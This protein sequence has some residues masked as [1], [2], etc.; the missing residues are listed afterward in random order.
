MD[1][2]TDMEKN[3]EEQENRTDIIEDGEGKENKIDS[4]DVDDE[5]NI[6]QEHRQYGGG[7]KAK[8]CH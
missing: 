1:A 3:G 5:D 8:I 4:M 2:E 6:Y 7:W